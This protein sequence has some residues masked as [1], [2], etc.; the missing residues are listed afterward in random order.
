ML[1]DSIA[2]LGGVKSGLRHTAGGKGPKF[3]VLFSQVLCYRG[4]DGCAADGRH[5]LCVQQHE[6]PR[7]EWMAGPKPRER[8][9]PAR[10]PIRSD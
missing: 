3:V 7:P 8:P 1:G 6:T 10:T 4:P 5:A 9:A 2:A